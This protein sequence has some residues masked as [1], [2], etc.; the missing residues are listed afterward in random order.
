MN[1]IAAEIQDHGPD[2]IGQALAGLDRRAFERA[3]QELRDA[4]SSIRQA[5]QNL[6]R[7]RREADEAKSAYAAWEQ[8]AAQAQLEGRTPEPYSGP[9]PTEAQRMFAIG[10]DTVAAM[11]LASQQ[12]VARRAAAREALQREVQRRLSTA[13]VT[14]ADS[15]AECWCALELTGA[16]PA[17]QPYHPAWH[18]LAVPA[19][20]GTRGDDTSLIVSNHSAVSHRDRIR[21]MLRGIAPEIVK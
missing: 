9:S 1:A 4:D 3:E 13:Y 5:E 14:L 17:G 16:Q 18:R 12:A 2:I 19:P 11:R 20:V 8:Q 7:L 21:A 6:H 15:L 10:T